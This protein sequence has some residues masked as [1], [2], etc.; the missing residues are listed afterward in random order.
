MRLNPQTCLGGTNKGAIAAPCSPPALL[1]FVRY[2]LN[3]C[4]ERPG[5]GVQLY[6][7]Y[8]YSNDQYYSCDSNEY[9]AKFRRASRHEAGSTSIS[10]FPRYHFLASVRCQYVTL[11]VI[12]RKIV[13]VSHFSRSFI[14][15]HVNGHKK[16]TQMYFVCTQKCDTCR[17]SFN[18]ELQYIQV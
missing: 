4:T 10:P 5:F 15:I 3:L 6:R 11:S 17:L 14:L 12:F 2:I 18:I 13:G 8:E 16:C 1:S 7:Y 9:Y